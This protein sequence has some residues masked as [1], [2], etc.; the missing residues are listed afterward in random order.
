MVTAEEQRSPGASGQRGQ[1]GSGGE[2]ERLPGA[3]APPVDDRAEKGWRGRWMATGQRP[4]QKET[5]NKAHAAGH[6]T[7]PFLGG[8]L[9]WCWTASVWGLCP[10]PI[11]TA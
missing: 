10:M 11:A 1:T 4:V 2:R 3:E 8:S 7:V 6:K 9:W 5:R